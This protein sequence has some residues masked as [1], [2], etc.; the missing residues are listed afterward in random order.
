MTFNKQ[1]NGRRT[2]VESTSNCCCNRRITELRTCSG[3]NFRTPPTAFLSRAP[4]KMVALRRLGH[5]PRYTRCRLPRPSRSRR[6]LYDISS[7]AVDGGGGGGGV[8]IKG[9]AERWRCSSTLSLSSPF[10]F[11]PI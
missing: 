2:A 3:S 7:C 8:F 10:H 6:R 5:R 11:G 4:R 1:S 9:S